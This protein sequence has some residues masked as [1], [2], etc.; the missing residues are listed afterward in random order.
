MTSSSQQ[1]IPKPGKNAAGGCSLGNADMI[2]RLTRCLQRILQL[3]TIP[4]LCPGIVQVFLPDFIASLAG[5]LPI[6]KLIP[7]GCNCQS[8]KWRLEDM[9]GCNGPESISSDGT[10]WN[11]R[12]VPVDVNLHPHRQRRK[13]GS[14][15]KLSRN[16]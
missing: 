13:Q 7:R 8:A 16:C 4:I 5:M 14:M 15:R 12:D 10:V 1:R 9:R 3:E 6:L 11:M 2:Q